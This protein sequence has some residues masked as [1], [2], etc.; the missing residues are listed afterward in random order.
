MDIIVGI[1]ATWRLASLL[2]RE[3]GP[4]AVFETLRDR[5]GVRFD[6]Y[7]HCV[8]DNEVGKSLCCIW[9][10]SLWCG[11]IVALLLGFGRKSF[12]VGMALG[13]GAIYLEKEINE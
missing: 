9:C 3:R 2:I 4:F 7:S 10:T 12:V 8:A 6:D 5:A 11:W 13:A 1:F